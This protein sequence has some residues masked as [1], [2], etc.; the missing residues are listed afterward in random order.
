MQ[1]FYQMPFEAFEC[2]SPC[3]TPEDVAEF[4]RPYVEA[5]CST[6]DVIPCAADHETAVAA[7]GELGR[8]LTDAA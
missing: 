5:G 6:F 8:L 7:V 4:L 2:F 3:G 1:T